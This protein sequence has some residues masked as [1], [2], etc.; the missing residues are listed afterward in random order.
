[1]TPAAFL[2][3]LL[4]AIADDG[5]VL[6]LIV[7]IFVAGIRRTWVWGR[8]VDRLERLL[9]DER[10]DAMGRMNELRTEAESWRR[11]ALF[12]SG[13]PKPEGGNPHE[14]RVAPDPTEGG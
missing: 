4:Q 9:T 8:E 2:T 14:S 6:V 13:R 11:I 10:V 12:Q 5:P 1:V 7:L 3:S